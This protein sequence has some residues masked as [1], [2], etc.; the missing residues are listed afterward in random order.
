VS[1]R[2]LTAL[3]TEIARAAT[4]PGGQKRGLLDSD[5]RVKVSLACRLVLLQRQ[6]SGKWKWERD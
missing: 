4:R 2:L 3:L 5:S 1:A 6:H